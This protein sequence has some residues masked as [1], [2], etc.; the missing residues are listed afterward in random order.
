MQVL[1]LDGP[2][3]PGSARAAEVL[4]EG[5][6]VLFPRL[7]F[8]L[9]DAE[10]PLLDPEVLAPRCKNVSL[11]RATGRLRGTRLEAEAAARAAAMMT[12]FSD[13]AQALLGEVAP[14]WAP[15]LQRRRT[16]FRPAPVDTRV[17][18]PRKDDRRLHVDAF[19][20]SPVQGRRIVRVFA[21]VDP[22]GRP[23]V[24]NL[25]EDGFETFAS[26]FGPR[27]PSAGGSAWRER[28]GLTRGR[29]TA[30][31][32]AMLDL[33][34]RAKLDDGWQAAALG[35][36]LDLPAGSSWIVCTDA[37]LHAALSGQHALEQTWLMPVEAM[38]RP[39]LSPLRVLERMAGRALV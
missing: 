1:E 21:N 22:H 23:R 15:A 5:G 38:A 6:L 8:G 35:R 17:L 24:W 29:R 4:E 12:R 16:S 25:G 18:S 30:Y 26:Q 34:D 9:T 28:L 13:W 39:A 2:S 27:F 32:A 3:A 33:H 10:Q 7:R 19:P 11:D 36:R 31:D 37:V 14:G 20:A